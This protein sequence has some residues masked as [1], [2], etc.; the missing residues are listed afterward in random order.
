MKINRIA[1]QN[2]RRFED[3]EIPIEDA[4]KVLF[5]GDNGAGKSTVLTSVALGL[6][7]L[8]LCHA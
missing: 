3:L 5:I 1:L 4:S 8:V 7:W 2:Y 6:S